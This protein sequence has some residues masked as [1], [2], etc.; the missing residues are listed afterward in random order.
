MSLLDCTDCHRPISSEAIACP[1]CGRP[2]RDRSYLT[3]AGQVVVGGLVLVACFAWPPLFFVWLLVVI[4]RFVAR[5]RRS[6]TKVVYGAG[7][8][9]LALTMGLMWAVPGLALIVFAVGAGAVV[10]LVLGH[11]AAVRSTA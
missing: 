7:G 6:G 3:P 5:A 9:L 11:L 2:T 8:L 4:G 10:W 1:A